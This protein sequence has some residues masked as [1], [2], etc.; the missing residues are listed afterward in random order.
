MAG[1]ASFPYIFTMS[2]SI[3]F[4]STKSSGDV[5]ALI[6]RPRDATVMMVLAHGAGAGMRSGFMEAISRELSLLRIAVFRYQFPY[7]EKGRRSPDPQPVLKATVESAIRTA[8]EYADGLPVIAGGKSMGGRMTSM[9]S[10]PEG[11]KGLV[12]FGFPLHAPGKQSAER[13]N[14]LFGVKVPMLFLQGSRDRLASPDLLEPVI[15]K[16]GEMATLRAIEGAD[17]S[18]H[19]AKSSGRSDED[20]LREIAQIAA[21]WAAGL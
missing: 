2:T 16:L 14:H 13:A 3:S 19:M 10:L 18:F 4:Q 15:A 5:G 6:D 17:H 20:V 11:V 12:F 7:A 1:F 21:D 8:M 9:S